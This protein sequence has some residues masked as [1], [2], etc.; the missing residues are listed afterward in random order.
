MSHHHELGSKCEE[1]HAK[2]SS[3]VICPL[4]AFRLRGPER[5]A[6]HPAELA[7]LL[8]EAGNQCLRS[9]TSLQDNEQPDPGLIELSNS[10]TEFVNEICTALRASRLRIVRSRRSARAQDPPG[11]MPSCSR[12]GQAG[13][14][15]E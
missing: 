15:V 7:T 3:F 13:D 1:P 10:N 11:N 5:G 9:H 2:N 8:G 6:E 14:E 4:G 12:F